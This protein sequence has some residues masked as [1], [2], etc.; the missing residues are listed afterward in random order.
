[1]S[2]EEPTI[3]AIAARAILFAASTYGLAPDVLCKRVGLDPEL[4]ADVDGRIPV[5]IMLRL[6]AETG[7][8]DPDF[9]LHLAEMSMT[10]MAAQ[11]ALPW[12]LVRASATL[13]EGILRLVA[14]W[15][16]FNDLHPPELVLPTNAPDSFGV[17]RMRTKDTPHPVPRHASEYSFAWFVLAARKATG[18]DVSPLKI[19]FEHP[20]PANISEHARIFRCPVE[21]DQDGTA[22]TF[23]NS[24][25]DLPTLSGGE[26]D[27]VRLLERHT[28]HL[29]SKLP[30]RGGFSARVRAAITPLLA[31]SDVSID[32]IAAELQS[33]PRSI[34]RKLRDEGTTYQRVLDDLRKEVATEYLSQRAH[35]IAEV[36]LLLGFSD[37]T[38]FHRAF[39]RWTGRTP[40]DVRRGASSR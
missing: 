38:A 27:L 5:S 17:L 28:E 3:S 15:R 1:M 24:A 22:I 11:A 37:Q 36:A 39:V 26:D 14:A 16:V 19:Q 34:Q 10:S 20:R 7:P 6:W 21:F 25:M 31:A 12:H 2:V 35:S 30:A 9:G 40:G 23:P 29:L 13:K 32:R 8:L 4:A 18:V 33:S